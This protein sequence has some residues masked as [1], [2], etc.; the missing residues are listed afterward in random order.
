MSIGKIIG[1]KI[2]FGLICN[3]VVVCVV[4]LFYGVRFMILFVS[5]IR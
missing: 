2:L 1:I 4:G 3:V 5:I